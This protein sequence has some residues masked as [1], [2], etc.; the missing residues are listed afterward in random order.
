MSIIKVFPSKVELIQAAA[1]EFIDAARQ[2]IKA[3][4]TFSV[5]LSGGDTPQPLYQLLAQDPD[6]DNLDWSKIHF[7]WGDE[8]NVPP[9]HTDSNYFQAYQA[10]LEPRQIPTQNI[11]R[12]QGE[13]EPTIAADI[14]QAE[15]LDLFGRDLP[16]F[17]LIL[18]GMGSDGHTV[19]L[20]PG[21]DAV[22]H[23]DSYQLVAANYLPEPDTW[24]IT[25]MPKIINAAKRVIFL[26]SGQ[27]KAVSLHRVIEGPYLP[28][29]YPAQLIQPTAG[30]LI[31]LI[32]QEAGQYLTK[33]DE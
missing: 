18:L 3:K 21:T 27:S 30:K 6:R 10:L 12:I 5:A 20:F 31:W 1:V 26:I 19:S 13:L 4:G 7:F 25:L 15:L 9:A 8:R 32:G 29:L 33:F 2:S 17:D 11:H 24:R 22:I 28:H 14:Y 23:P 16:Q